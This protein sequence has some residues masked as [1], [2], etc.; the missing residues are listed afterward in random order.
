MGAFSAPYWAWRST[1]AN[2][3]W[4]D[5]DE[6]APSEGG[7]TPSDDCSASCLA[8]ALHCRLRR[9]ARIEPHLDQERAGAHH[10]QRV[11]RSVDDLV[12]TQKHFHRRH[13]ERDDALAFFRAH[14]G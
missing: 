14:R 8:S 10:E 5:N 7:N 6:C 3:P 1:V 4:D 13:D 9:L 11:V 12:Q 2:V